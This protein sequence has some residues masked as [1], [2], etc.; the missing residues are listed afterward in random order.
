M[1]QDALLCNLADD[2]VLRLARDFENI[3][4]IKDATGDLKRCTYLMANKPER[5]TL[6][7]G[8]DFSALAFMLAGGSG[9]FQLQVI[10]AQVNLVKCV[11]T[12]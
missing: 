12:L 2:T 5:F 9:L 1:Y 6:L 11:L 7:S 4:A 3:V 8:D 10:F